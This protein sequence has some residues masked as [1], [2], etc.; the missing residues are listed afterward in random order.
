MKSAHRHELETNV[1]AT[2][3]EV[4]IE[5]YKPYTAQILGGIIA[6]VAL[7]MIASYMWGSSSSRS[8]EAWDTYNRAV[9]S[10]AFGGGPSL[11][12]LRRTSQENAG[13][14]IQQM[15]DVTWAD[16]TVWNAAHG[17][18]ANRAKALE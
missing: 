2:K 15:A 6:A 18:L 7:I 13:T 3:L 16:A 11:D 10:A 1:L 5:R 9:T 17:Y 12:D 8:S 4:M 14:P